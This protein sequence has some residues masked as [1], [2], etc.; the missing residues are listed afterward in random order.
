M[1]QPLLPI[2]AATFLLAARGEAASSA[3]AGP[4]AVIASVHGHVDVTSARGGASAA[5]FGRPLERGDKVA[6]GKGGGATLFFGDGNVVTLAERSSI[7]IGAAAGGAPKSAALPA[8]VYSHVSGFVTAGSRQTG[9]VT[10]ADMRAESDAGAPLLLAPRNC[11]ILEDAPALRWR[12]VQGATRYRVHFGPADGA[13][14]WTREVPAA[15]GAEVSLAFP[16]DAARLE[17]GRDYEW[18]VE[19]LD[20]KGTMRRESARM[21]A[22]PPDAGAAVRE[23]LGRIAASAGGEHT[24]AACFLAGSYLSGMGLHGDAAVRFRELVT[25]APESPEA[26]E[27][28][29]NLYL[30]IGLSDWAAAEFRQALALHR[31]PH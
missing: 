12:A 10:M 23:N 28:L 20:D 27:A 22:L 2:L 25:L 17:P 26:H 3:P 11:A 21:K 30:E 14:T 6:V 31:E 9:L 18:E 13:E 1:R 15:A 24:P 4:V 5:V 8:D 29:G 7:T 16:G 19:A